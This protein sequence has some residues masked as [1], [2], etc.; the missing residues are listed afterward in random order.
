ML[1]DH[2]EFG[3]IRI[4]GVEYDSDVIVLRGQVHS[5]WWRDAGGHVFAPQDL[6]VVIGNAPAV[7][8]LGIGSLGRVKVREETIEAF[9]MSGTRVVIDR[10]GP[11]VDEY[12]RLA[13]GGV[14]VAAALHLTC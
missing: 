14:D 7:V 4:A 8:C 9:I 11:V 12:N 2:Y 3:K 1:I 6:G 13:Q 10:T 5:P